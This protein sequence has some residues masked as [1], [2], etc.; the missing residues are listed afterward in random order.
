MEINETNITNA[1]K[2][3]HENLGDIFAPQIKIGPAG[4]RIMDAVAIKKTWAPRTVIGYEIKISRQDFLR[5]QKHPAYMENCNIFYFVVPKGIIEK[6]E[7][8]EGAGVMVYNPE[9]KSLR[10]VKKAPYRKVPINPDLLLHIMFWKFDRYL[11]YR[12]RAEILEDC[13]AKKDL[14]S[15]GKSISK[16][17]SDLEFQISSLKRNSYKERYEELQKEWN[18]KF[19]TKF[20]DLEDIPTQGGLSTYDIKNLKRNIEII[21]NIINKL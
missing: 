18:E 13:K 19:G 10:T 12:T 5:D 4:S 14:K 6:G 17:I 20:I 15:L 8:P 3:K 21:S 9:T 16:K 2:A 7:I 1:L 11:G